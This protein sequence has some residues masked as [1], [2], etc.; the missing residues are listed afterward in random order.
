M[1]GI[2]NYCRRNAPIGVFDSGVGGISVLAAHTK[3]MPN[4]DFIYYGDSANAPYG[5][6]SAS[7]VRTVAGAVTEK[8]LSMGAKAIVIACNTATSAAAEALRKA[9]PHLPI[10]GMEPAVKPAAMSAEHPTVLVMA[11]PLTIRET[12]LRCLME[13]YRAEADFID[14]PCHGLVELVE[15]GVTEGD[16][17]DELLRR[18]LAP[19]IEGRKIDAAVLGCTHYIHVKASIKKALGCSVAI[20]DGAMGTARETLHRLEAAELNAPHDK[21]GKVTIYN[22]SENKE[23]LTLSENL[24]DIAK[25]RKD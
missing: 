3:V 21:I 25:K 12:K 19:C 1:D 4:E 17:M 13:R 5:E 22:S 16:E 24:F 11:T 14:A 9:Y 8:L 6:K 10:I 2:M 7:E 23:L 18:N 20:F 15:R